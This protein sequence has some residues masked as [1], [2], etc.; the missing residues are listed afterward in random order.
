MGIMNYI[1]AKIYGVSTPGEYLKKNLALFCNIND[2]KNLKKEHCYKLDKSPYYPPQTAYLQV[3]FCTATLEGKTVAVVIEYDEDTSFT[4]G[5]I[6]DLQS[7]LKHGFLARSY[8]EGHREGRYFYDH[9]LYVVNE[10]K[11]LKNTR[12]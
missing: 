9:V 1:A 12:Q 11:N 8:K 4:Q 6:I 5:S 10:T 2:L 3:Y 7:S